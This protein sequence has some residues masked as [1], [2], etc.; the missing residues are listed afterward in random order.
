MEAFDPAAALAARPVIHTM[1]F[2]RGTVLQALAQAGGCEELAIHLI[3]SGQV[4]D[5]AALSSSAASSTVPD[6][7]SSGIAFGFKPA[8]DS[9]AFTSSERLLGIFGLMFCRFCVD[10]CGR[11][12]TTSFTAT[13]CGVWYDAP[14]VS[15]IVTGVRQ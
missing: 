15:I 6:E 9:S 13:A 2:D 11:T 5:A 1:G 10:W 4:H 14:S 8:V 12:S 7:D 3:L